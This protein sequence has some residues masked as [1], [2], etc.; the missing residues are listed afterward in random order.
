MNIMNAPSHK[1]IRKVDRRRFFTDAAGSA[2]GVGMMGFGLSLVAGQAHALPAVAL[3]PPGA[4]PENEF[5]SACVH[6]GQCA[7]DCPYDTLRLSR[8]GSPVSSG[9]PYFIARDVPCEMCDDIPCVAACP[10]GALSKDLTDIDEAEMGVAVLVGEETCL[11]KLG[12]RC[13]VCYRVCPAIDKAIR[14]DRQ[15]NARSGSHAMF[16]P[17]VD[18]EYCT[19]CGKCE[20]S[21]V[22]PTSAIKVLPRELALGELGEHYRLG[23]KE[24]ERHGRSLVDDIIDLPNRM[25]DGPLKESTP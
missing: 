25:P 2:C 5:L 4:L 16:I 13:D 12:L 9:T 18:S 3:R 22:L 11:N 23:W 14:L 10:T 21:C 7:A 15:H 1:T 17:V 20:R 24:K 8:F 19:G 6:C